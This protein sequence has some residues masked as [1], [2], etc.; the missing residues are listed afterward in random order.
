M[1]STERW[2]KVRMT[3]GVGQLG[4]VQIWSVTER[5]VRQWARLNACFGGVFW[6]GYAEGG[7]IGGRRGRNKKVGHFPGR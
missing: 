3:G 5:V 2:N 7:K 1:R 4:W 6:S